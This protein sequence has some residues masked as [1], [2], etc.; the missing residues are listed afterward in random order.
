MNEW[1]NEEIDSQLERE[2]DLLVDEELTDAP[3]R[4][5]LLKLERTPDG[6]RHCALAFLE[7]QAWRGGAREWQSAP[8]AASTSPAASRP[9]RHWLRSGATFAAMAA[10]F[11][12]AFTLGLVLRGPHGPFAPHR[13]LAPHS[14]VTKS[15]SAAIQPALVANASTG[16]AQSSDPAPASPV[17]DEQLASSES[18]PETIWLPTAAASEDLTS[19]ELIRELEQHGHAVERRQVLWPV[20]LDDGRRALVP[21]ERLDVRYTGLHYE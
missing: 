12:M 20:E 4:E 2:L 13:P 6:W 10:S 8:S 19:S 15:P 9:A 17:A 3:R 16:V 1:R 21:I 7:A 11:L 5:L 14:Q 18:R